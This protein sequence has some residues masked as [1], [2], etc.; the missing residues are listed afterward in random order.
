MSEAR[1]LIY[2]L[3]DPEGYAD[4][5]VLHTLEAFRS[6]ANHILVVSNGALLPQSENELGKVADEVL[7]RENTGYDVGA[8]RA[9]LKHVGRKHLNSFSELVLANSTFFSVETNFKP[10]FD[11]MASSDADFWGLTDHPKVTPNPFTGTG[12]LDAHLQTYW[13]VVRE[14]MLHDPHFFDY[15][16]ETQDPVTYA[17]AVSNFE[18]RFSRHFAD[19]G[20]SWQAAFP[21][22]DFGVENPTMEAPL[23]LLG[24]GFPVVKKRLY[25]HGTEHLMNLGVSVARVTQAAVARGVSRE[26]IMDA[27]AR[28][29]EADQVSV[30]LGALYVVPTT[31]PDLEPSTLKWSVTNERPWRALATGDTHPSVRE[32][33]DTEAQSSANDISNVDI[34]F[35]EPSPLLPPRADGNLWRYENALR[36]TGNQRFL[37]SL[38]EEEARLGMIAP[39]LQ[40]VGSAETDVEWLANAR[41]AWKIAEMMGLQERASHHG[42]VAAYEGV[43]VYRTAALNGFGE[44]IRKA[45]GWQQLVDVAG[46]E[47]ALERILDQLAADHMLL[48]G[49]YA[50]R[51]TTSEEL[52]VEAPLWMVEAQAHF[53]RFKGYSEYMHNWKVLPSSPSRGQAF[54]VRSGGPNTYSALNEAYRRFPATYLVLNRLYNKA[55]SWRE[56]RK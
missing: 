22:A 26:M 16:Q 3:H 39:T 7:V 5:A 37:V 36:A 33:G 56:E 15:W 29:T 27:V 24:Q 17:Q 42:P 52:T 44:R 6:V 11:R 49:F 54:W 10:L 8:Y 13:V 1:L 14:K 53:A 12:T 4:L 23:A 30:A 45:G 18:S 9:G 43:A 38:M 40:F 2:L 21:A 41:R 55:R 20:F 35:V 19:L 48:G 25:F 47:D 32:L 28:R 51:A 50:G 31:D 34:L 46:S